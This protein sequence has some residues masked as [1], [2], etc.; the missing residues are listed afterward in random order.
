MS[1]KNIVFKPVA[2]AAGAALLSSFAFCSV[3][4]ASDN[5]FAAADLDS[6]YLVS[7]DGPA[8]GAADGD[9]QGDKGADGKCGEGKCGKDMGE[10]G[11]CGEGKCGADKGADGQCGKDM[12]GEG[13]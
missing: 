7:G 5:P 1:Q 9:S 6:G 12:G 4:V 8:D 11:K 3:A 13:K 2:A 10:D